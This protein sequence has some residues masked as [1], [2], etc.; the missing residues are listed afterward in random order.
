M[1]DTRYEP[2]LGSYK[3][4]MSYRLAITTMQLQVSELHAKIVMRITLIGSVAHP[5]Y[6]YILKGKYYF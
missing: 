1:V 5:I 4:L 2:S 6:R 3:I